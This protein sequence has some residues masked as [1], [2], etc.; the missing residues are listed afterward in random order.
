M[1]FR[2]RASTEESNLVVAPFDFAQGREVWAFG[3][4]FIGTGKRMSLTKP[5]V[6]RETRLMR[7]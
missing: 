2:C 7:I 5:F 3:M 4:V 6:L 1:L